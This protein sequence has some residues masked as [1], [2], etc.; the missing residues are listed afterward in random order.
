MILPLCLLHFSN[1]VIF[2]ECVNTNDTREQ[3][4]M[5]AL[6]SLGYVLLGFLAGVLGGLV[7]IGGGIIIVPALVMLFGMSQHTA[8]GT[9]IA[10]LVLPVG[11]VAAWTYYK[12]GHVVL[13]AA[14]LIALGFLAGAGLGA[15]FAQSLSTPALE[16]IFGGIMILVG[17]KMIFG[18]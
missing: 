15:R 5:N 3:E 11:I 4:I 8:Q 13:G 14:L 16:K 18:R 2:C 10:M 12:E 7:G 6:T 1:I 17:L 9:T